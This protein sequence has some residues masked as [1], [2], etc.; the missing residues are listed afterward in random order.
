MVLY[1]RP[2]KRKALPHSEGKGFLNEIYLFYSFTIWMALPLLKRNVNTPL[3]NCC[4]LMRCSRLL[5][6]ISCS[7]RPL[8]SYNRAGEFNRLLSFN[9]IITL[10]TAGLG[11]TLTGVTAAL[12]SVITGE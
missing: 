10:L 12:A 9:R 3:A 4:R 2:I 5:M 1:G 6:R 7:N 8:T 11:Y